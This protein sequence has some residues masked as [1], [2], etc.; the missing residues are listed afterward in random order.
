MTTTTASELIDQWIKKSEGETTPDLAELTT[1]LKSAINDLGAILDGSEPMLALSIDGNHKWKVI[2]ASSPWESDRD[3]RYTGDTIRVS[4]N[5]ARPATWD[6]LRAKKKL[7]LRP[8]SALLGLEEEAETIPFALDGQRW[9]ETTKEYEGGETEWTLHTEFGS[10]EFDLEEC[11]IRYR[12]EG[13]TAPPGEYLRIQEK[14]MSMTTGEIGSSVRVDDRGLIWQSLWG[15][16]TTFM[17]LSSSGFIP[18]I[19]EIDHTPIASVSS[20]R[21]TPSDMK[22]II[23]SLIELAAIYKRDDLQL[24]EIDVDCVG[25]SGSATELLAKKS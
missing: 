4:R 16:S 9:E 1:D 12:Y 17:G 2:L 5:G 22:D 21:L 25:F 13:T 14:G 8:T 3:G 6:E 11:D 15:Y 24:D 20:E 18:D 23:K 7:W 19:P 10:L